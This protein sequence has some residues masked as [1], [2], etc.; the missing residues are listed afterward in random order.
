MSEHAVVK[1]ED[2]GGAA[3]VPTSVKLVGAAT[4]AFADVAGQGLSLDLAAVAAGDYK[5]EL[6]L[7]TRPVMPFSVKV[8]ESG[9][10]K[11]LAFAGT[12]PMC[13][14]LSTQSAAA[15][16][17]ASRTLVVAHFVLAPKHE[18]IVL[19]AGWDYSGGADNTQYAKT[20]RDDLYAGS[21]HQTGSKKAITRVVFDHTVVTMFDFKSGNRIRWMKGRKDWHTMDTV[22]QGTVATNT[23]KYSTPANEQA[24][25][26]DDAISIVHVYGYVADLGSTAAA[27]LKRFDIF[28]HAWAGGPILVDTY[29]NAEF[30]RGARSAERD[31]GDKDGRIKDFDAVNM[32]R[33]ADFKSAF[34]A[35]TAVAKMWG[36]FATTDYRKLVRAA[37]KATDK[38]AKLKVTLS[39]GEHETTANDIEAFFIGTLLPNTYMAAM[40]RLVGIAVWGAPLGM[41]A[42]LRAVGSRNYMFVDQST[43]SLEFKWFQDELGLA[44]DPTG[45]IAFS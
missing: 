36:C 26:D 45:Y 34:D 3:I 24:R 6:E 15:G 20:W 41:G 35:A 42:N 43:Y 12:A 38:A 18:E 25:H 11:A 30:D 33:S 32:P 5:L 22:L 8:T 44:P 21:S 23:G 31:P 2:T 17:A 28:S 29:Q 40:A 4:H 13:C 19:V 27:S 14:T 9:A 1:V 7:P 10:S 37:A 39:D 16:A